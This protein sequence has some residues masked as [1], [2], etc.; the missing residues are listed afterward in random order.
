MQGGKLWL[1]LI[2]LEIEVD[3][4]NGMCL[5]DRL[6][7]FEDDSKK[8]KSESFASPAICGYLGNSTYAKDFKKSKQVP[9]PFYNVEKEGWFDG[10]VACSK[11]IIINSYT[12]AVRYY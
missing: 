3:R 11:S 10:V 7:I 5:A 4:P 8:S 6:S 12:S 2:S 9:K 1:R